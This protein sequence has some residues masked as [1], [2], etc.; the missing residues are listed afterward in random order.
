MLPTRG[1]AGKIR[2][3][4]RHHV[5]YMYSSNRALQYKLYFNTVCFDFSKENNLPRYIKNIKI[6]L[7]IIINI[8]IIKKKPFTEKV[9]GKLTMIS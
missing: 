9:N 2:T 8:I 6:L 1:S 3:T 4:L 7:N 5:L